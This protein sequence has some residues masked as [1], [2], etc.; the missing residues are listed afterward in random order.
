[1]GTSDGTIIG[2]TKVVDHGPDADR[3]NLVFLSDGYQNTE[4][5]QFAA[6]VQEFID[7]FFTVPPF[8]ELDIQ[9]AFNI[10]RVDVSSTDSGADDPAACGAG[11]TAAT[12]FDGTFCADGVIQRLTGVNSTTVTNVLNA[13]VPNWDQAIVIINSPIRGGSG[14]QIATATTGGADFLDVI[15][16]EMGH[17]AFGLADEY[18]YWQGCTSGETDRDN[19]PAVE[20]AEPNVTIDSNRTTI[21]WGSLIAGATP[22]PT[23]NN[24]DCTQCDSQGS[25]VVAGTVGAFEG[26][27]YYHCDCF[28]PE[29]NCMMRN[30]GQPFCVVCEA[31]IRDT[32]APY[33]SPTTVSLD[34][35]SVIFNDVPEGIE[36]PG[37]AVFTVDSC[38]EITFEI[39]SG[40][41]VTSGPAGTQF[42][43]PLGNVFVSTTTLN[44]RQ[45]NVWI[46]YLG[47]APGDIATG[48]MTVRCV[49]TGV[50]YIIPITANTVARPTVAAVM[51]LDK[52]GSMTEDSGIPGFKRIDVL[53]YSAPPFVDLLPENNAVGIVS[54]DHDAYP[55]MPVT[56]PLAPPSTLEADRLTAKGHIAG[57]TPN[58][59]GLT[60][61]GDGVELAH[62]ELTPVIG[63]DVKATIVLTDGHETAAKYISE[64]TGLINERVYAIG[65][66]TADQI[67]PSAL[68]ALTNGTGG[69]MLM[70]GEIGVSEYFRLSKYYLQILAGVTNTD[71]VVDPEGML[72]PGY[73]HRIPFKLNETDIYTDVIL[74]SPGKDMI[75]FRVET[76]DA[77]II[78][79]GLA[80]GSP[81]MSYVEGTGTN[82]YRLSLPVL[83]GGVPSR[84]GQWH[85]LLK[86][87]RDNFR[88]YLNSLDNYPWLMNSAQAHGI[89]YSLSVHAYSN[90]RMDTRVV[91]SGMEPGA[92]L[93][94][95]VTLTEYGLPIDGRATVQADLERPDHSTALLGLVET[96]P[97][98]FETSLIATQAGIY[99]FLAR[100]TGTTLR[101]RPFTRE[102]AA[103]GVVWS[104]GDDPFPTD[105]TRPGD[106]SLCRLLLCL[107]NERVMTDEYVRRLEELGIDIRAFRKCVEV[108]CREQGR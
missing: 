77:Q 100:A 80:G 86:T 22:M 75:L 92:T 73:E 94:L 61:I 85:A 6:D 55:V 104:G 64:V 105:P 18:E 76:P 13:Q 57:H 5:A 20:P 79:P 29:F 71:I 58:P 107:L 44:P 21:K 8:S 26:A 4:M 51:V 3:F 99:T 108:I 48:T 43:T 7:Y 53:H 34:T 24:A 49:E 14:G 11:T 103:T 37:S 9:C 27:H 15:I 96:A 45:A 65:L 66:G 39:I 82:Y 102:Q 41:T 35:P 106:V 28:R 81:G 95:R 23:T 32:L 91:Q 56:G 70:T 40:P 84:S 69:Y 59:A 60:A 97:G 74:L 89:R 52:S 90:L 30:T 38:L 36:A 16:H 12:Y 68:T 50:D 63:Y 72:L 1:M 54:F 33:T 31:E 93:T 17:S 101:G 19:H 83:V 87:N 10:H 2:A 47:T 62:N 46:T 78:D 67:Q 42:N 88:T 98:V 25:P